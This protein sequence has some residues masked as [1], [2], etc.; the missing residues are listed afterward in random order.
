MA[1]ENAK[2][3][4]NLANIF[5]I[6]IYGFVLS[7]NLF[8]FFKRTSDLDLVASE[9]KFCKTKWKQNVA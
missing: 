3:K 1:S 5:E 4:Y 9:W 6:E 7:F 2:Q 8:W